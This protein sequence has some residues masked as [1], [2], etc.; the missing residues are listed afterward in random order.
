MYRYESDLRKEI[1]SVPDMARFLQKSMREN[2]KLPFTSEELKK[3]KKVVITG[4]G[5]SLCAAYAAKAAFEELTGL[6]IDTPTCLDLARHYDVR[7]FGEPGDTLVILVSFSGKVSR[8]VEAAMRAKKYG[9]VTMAVT[10]FEDS[11]VAEACDRVLHVVPDEFD[12]HRTPGCRT[13]VASML[14]LFRFAIHLGETIGI[15]LNPE[16]YISEI[17]ANIDLWNA[18]IER[19][20]KEMY[21]LA[22]SWKPVPYFEALGAGP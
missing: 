17:D 15:V 2:A 11:P 9:A 18:E 4:C 10:H 7:R 12:L 20:E 16:N 14:S 3:F 5:D 13:Y 22:E 1:L 19:L 21:E 8:V 6:F